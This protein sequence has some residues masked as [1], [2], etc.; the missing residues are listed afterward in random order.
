MSTSTALMTAEELLRLPRGQYRYELI[1]GELKTMSPAGHNHGRITMRLSSPLAQFV[2]KNQLG[3]VFAAETGFKLT[4]SP[5]TVLAPDVSFV[6]QSRAKLLRDSQ[7]YWPGPPDLAVEVISPS[8]RKVD[9]KPKTLKWF[10]HGVKEVWIVD[11]KHE[12]VTIYSSPENASV[13]TKDEQLS[14][15]DLLPGFSLHLAEV[16]R[17]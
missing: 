16:F 2:W 8:E 5:D 14:S 6:S 17:A 7:G 3:E 1:N 12:T 11:L 13:V 15:G 10:E 4:T 9:V